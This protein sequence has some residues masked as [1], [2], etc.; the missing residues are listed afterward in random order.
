MSS[1]ATTFSTEISPFDANAAPRI[2][3]APEASS[4][5][6]EKVVVAPWQTSVQPGA[7]ETAP[8]MLSRNG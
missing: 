3:P 5:S 2:V 7:T 6:F 4:F 1:F 8:A